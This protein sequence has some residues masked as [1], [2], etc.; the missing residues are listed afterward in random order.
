MTL[1]LYVLLIY[2][3]FFPDKDDIDPTSESW[4]TRN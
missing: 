1:I 4:D 3:H 2:N